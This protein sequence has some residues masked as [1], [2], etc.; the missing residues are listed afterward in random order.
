M[1]SNDIDE[2]T[3]KI[4]EDHKL[5]ETF[6]NYREQ[7]WT[8]LGGEFNFAKPFHKVAE[9]NAPSD[10]KFL[11]T[12]VAPDEYFHKGVQ[13]AFNSNKWLK[14]F[15]GFGLG[16]LGITVLSQFFFGKLKEPRRQKWLVQ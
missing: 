16:L 12:G 7:V 4:L 9:S 14:I 10:I 15:G 11:L 13:K 2:D 3:L 8:K 5:K 6:L 1:F